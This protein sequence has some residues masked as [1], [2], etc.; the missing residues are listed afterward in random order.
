M[1]LRLVRG[2]AASRRHGAAHSLRFTEPAGVDWAEIRVPALVRVEIT[3]AAPISGDA[4]H[5]RFPPAQHA[6]AGI[7]ELELG[8]DCPAR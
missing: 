7:I 1:E 6:R 4:P 5:R 3:L 8:G 2:F